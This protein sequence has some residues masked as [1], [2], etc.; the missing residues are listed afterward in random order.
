[1]CGPEAPPPSD[2]RQHPPRPLPSP[3]EG[4]PRK[5]WD[6]RRRRR[7][8]RL[9][10][11]LALLLGLF[12]FLLYLRRHIRR[13]RR[14]RE[15]VVVVEELE[16]VRAGMQRPGRGQ[17]A[18]NSP[19]PPAQYCRPAAVEVSNLLTRLP[20]TMII[21]IIILSDGL[22]LRLLLLLSLLLLYTYLVRGTKAWNCYCCC[23]L[24]F[25]SKSS[26]HNKGK[27]HI[28]SAIHTMNR[29]NKPMHTATEGPAHICK[30]AQRIP[31][32]AHTNK[33]HKHSQLHQREPT[34]Y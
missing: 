27:K 8:R 14:Q 11:S 34:Q 12:A 1:M 5:R 20:I 33:A 6:H 30:Q 21:I 22:E 16:V 32:T 15:A 25:Y 9:V 13:R 3:Q 18:C 31:A 24:F 7:R 29:S 10:R 19:R 17:H 28:I 4:R 23:C 2:A 26:M